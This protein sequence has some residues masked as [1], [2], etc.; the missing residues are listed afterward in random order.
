MESVPS[1]I[2]WKGLDKTVYNNPPAWNFPVKFESWESYPWNLPSWPRDFFLGGSFTILNSM[3]LSY[4]A[5][6][7]KFHIEGVVVACVFHDTG[8]FCP[9]C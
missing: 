1:S 6:K 5:I 4:W 3:F 7:Y 9:K 2:F 8:Q